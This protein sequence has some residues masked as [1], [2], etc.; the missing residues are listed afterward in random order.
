MK[1]WI[2]ITMICLALT[3]VSCLSAWY[4]WNKFIYIPPGDWQI[5]GCVVDS[6]GGV[7]ISH[8]A[9]LKISCDAGSHAGEYVNPKKSS[10]YLWIKQE[11]RDGT[12]VN[13]GLKIQE[14]RQ[15][16][17][18]TFPDESASGFRPVNLWTDVS[19]ETHI[20]KVLEFLVEHRAK[21]LSRLV[22]QVRANQAAEEEYS[23]D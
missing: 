7:F 10:E 6:L 5:D 17:Y 11:W 3:A 21:L 20:E 8:K 23:P 13:F 15:V 12:R 19:D 22:S 16:L 18:V 2:L 1:R 14:G 9:G 4:I